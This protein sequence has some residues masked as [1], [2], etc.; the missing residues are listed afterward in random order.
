MEYSSYLIRH[1]IRSISDRRVYIYC[2]CICCGTAQINMQAQ[3]L[4]GVMHNGGQY[5]DGAI[6]KYYVANDSFVKI[7]DFD[8]IDGANPYASLVKGADDKLY[9]TT[10]AGGL[11]GGGGVIFQYDPVGNTYTKKYDFGSAPGLNG[12]HPDGTMVQFSNGKFYG[13]TY[14]N[15]LFMG[16][17]SLY[18]YDP[19]TDSVK[20]LHFFASA[21][22]QT[23]GPYYPVTGMTILNNK[24]YGVSLGGGD[25][26]LGLTYGVIFS[27]D[28]SDGSYKDEFYLTDSDGFNSQGGLS[29]ANGKLYGMAS[30][31]GVIS[32]SHY[33]GTIYE[34][35]V[36]DSSLTLKYDFTPASGISPT[37]KLFLANNGKMYGTTSY[38]DTSIRAT[39]F[40]YDTA[41]NTVTVMHAFN[42]ISFDGDAPNGGVIQASNGLLYGM[43]K[44]GGS[45]GDGTIYS[46]NYNTNTYKK[47][48]DLNSNTGTT[49]FGD[50]IE[51]NETTGI[52]N[53]A[54]PNNLIIYPNPTQTSICISASTPIGDIVISDLLGQVVYSGSHDTDHAVID[55]SHLSSGVYVIKANDNRVYKIVKE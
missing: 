31:G 32:G 25:T 35:S 4:Y 22:S 2:L 3:V 24:L 10:Q 48:M 20:F 9:G 11:G 13:T 21:L 52:R 19:A 47:L 50:F 14:S 7:H 39:L 38:S 37:C 18:E 40:Q 27:L 33:G 54:A 5:G 15:G 45:N 42:S 1:L 43:T 12:L 26:A 16:S 23:P 41:L 29:V 8:G 49:P 55:I 17:G 34:F 46:Y 44:Y 6:F 51:V 28:P 53:V 36:S 30:S